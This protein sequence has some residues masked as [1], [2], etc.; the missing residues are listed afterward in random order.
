MHQSRPSE[1]ELTFDLLAEVAVGAT[2]RVELCRIRGGTR[3][4]RLVAVKRLH[5]YI[6]DDPQ[7][8]DMFHDEVWMTA[9]LKN[10]HVV[11]VVGWGMAPGPWL[12]VELV[13]GVSLMRLMRT[14]FETGERFTERMIV[15]LA[16]CICDGLAAAHGLRGSSGE[17]LG[18]VHRD[19]TPGNI[20]LGF[21]GEVKIADFGLAKA[22]Q[23]LTKTL[24]GLLKGN[25][26]YMSPEQISGRT[27]DGRS[28]VFALG[29]LLF[30]LFC[31]RRP[32][33]VTSDLDAMRAI[34]DETPADLQSLRP[35]MDKA[36]VE[37]VLRCLE[38][39]PDR[40]W[41]T[42]YEL[43]ERFDQWLVAHGYR[44]DN[45]HSLARFVRRNAMRQMRWFERAIAGEFVDAT[46]A[47]SF[48]VGSVPPQA[49]IATAGLASPLAHAPGE[50]PLPRPPQLS[51]PTVATGSTAAEAPTPRHAAHAKSA[52]APAS[53]A[54]TRPSH[55]V[56]HGGPDGDDI[57]WGEDGPTL[58]QKSREAGKLIAAK[59][60][61][62]RLP[63]GEP[64]TQRQRR[65]GRGTTRR[66]AR[67]PARQTVGADGDSTFDA[68]GLENIARRIH[69]AASA[70]HDV[71][72]E[73]R[74]DTTVQIDDANRH[75]VEEELGV[76]APHDPDVPPLPHPTAGS[77]A[78][79]S[80]DGSATHLKALPESR[81]TPAPG[82][83]RSSPD[84]TATRVAQT[85]GVG[86]YGVHASSDE[87][88]V[89]PLPAPRFPS[90]PTLL[91]RS[92]DFFAEASR[93]GEEARRASD[94]SRRARAVADAAARAAA[95]ATEAAALA[96]AGDE[97]EA[98]QR[99]REAQLV[100]E[101][102]LRGEIPYGYGALDADD[103][104]A[105]QPRALGALARGWGTGAYRALRAGEGVTI[106][107]IISTGFVLVLL[108]SVLLWAC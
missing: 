89:M 48:N 66:M 39:E 102:L 30:E 101:A 24:T 4:G 50:A 100:N 72:Q 44:D 106:V 20:L 96:S 78:P 108:F 98:I 43:R 25:P 22:K 40:R 63:S 88:R 95:L 59:R 31:G 13:R 74:A 19:L 47:E 73:S 55:E 5:P 45:R 16:R 61:R 62:E 69:D 67:A 3:H 97:H 87:L 8:V 92:S 9:A 37:V 7:F 11:E 21:G 28:D 36:L 86:P 79:P 81:G 103:S 49:P 34:T 99:L 27:L 90:L 35:R 58:I 77:D 75:R 18:L 6:A 83:G 56:P 57:E 10:E 33:N 17:H 65:S 82:H 23:R 12:A 14:V 91:D 2:A 38:K 104:F 76:L 53:G 51:V 71:S 29:V 41:P 54:P 107:V 70:A 52:Q 94:T 84:G 105:A 93:L 15:Y 26:Q 85:V 42:A 80:P 1:G 60:N 46:Q 64:T 68:R 32:W